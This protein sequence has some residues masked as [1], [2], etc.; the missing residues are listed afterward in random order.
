MTIFVYCYAC[1]KNNSTVKNINPNKILNVVS[2][3]E[4]TDDN[5]LV[6]FLKDRFCLT[7]AKV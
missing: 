2:L 7:D 4:L 1:L 3:Y 5:S 6:D